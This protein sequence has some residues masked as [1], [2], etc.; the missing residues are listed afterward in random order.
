M[1][2]HRIRLR[3]PWECE[4]LAGP[5]Q[6]ADGSRP[7]RVNM[8]CRLHEI[9]L[10]S[11]GSRTLVRRRFGY[12]GRID[13]HER[14]WLIF[15]GVAGKLEVRLNDQDLGRCERS[16]EFEITPLLNERNILEITLE[17]T[18]IDTLVWDEVALEI[19][20]SAFLRNVHARRNDA[21]EL[22]V[23]GEVA[24]TCERPLD[25]YLLIDGVN[26]GYQAIEAGK[27]FRFVT[28]PMDQSPAIRVELVD[29]ATVWH[30]VEVRVHESTV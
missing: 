10:D 25:L 3:G 1:Y 5:E 13:A 7:R 19:R 22:L 21:G 14:V 9:G 16:C 18:G 30:T 29:A 15:A 28:Q 4:P 6:P 24:G 20:C 8:P 11:A 27:S 26:A 17:S 23:H 2:P 12:P